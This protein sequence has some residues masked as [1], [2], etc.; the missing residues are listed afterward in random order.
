M[1]FDETAWDKCDDQLASFKAALFNQDSIEKITDLVQHHR[2]TPAQRLSPPQKGSFNMVIRL[3]FTD[4]SSTIIRF[5][6][7]G[8]SVLPEEKVRH[9]VAVMRFLEQK[10]TI[11]VPHIIQHGTTAE[12][13]HAL[14]P[15]VIMDYVDNNADLVDALNTPGIPHS[16]R[17]VLDPNIGETALRSTYSEMAGLLLQLSKH[18]FPR[19]GC[20]SQSGEKWFVTHRPFSINMN[21]LVRASQSQFEIIEQQIIAGNQ[22]FGTSRVASQASQASGTGWEASED[23]GP[24]RSGRA[25]RPKRRRTDET[26]DL[27]DQ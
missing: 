1:F 3:H 23:E 13:P 16:N 21:E 27:T 10:T 18:A 7:P 2:K 12:S 5:P 6:I 22:A 9:E 25:P 24:R 8:Y 19:I 11:P 15:F 4:A 17:P 26:T 14:G 20:I